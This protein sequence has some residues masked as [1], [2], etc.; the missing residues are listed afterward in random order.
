MTVIAK[1]NMDAGI[2]LT[3]KEIARLD[4]ADCRVVAI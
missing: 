2:E 4:W 3:K 1:A